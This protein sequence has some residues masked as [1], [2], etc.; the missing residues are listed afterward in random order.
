MPLLSR[1]QATVFSCNKRFRV[2]VAGRRFGKTYL[3][4][5]ELLRGA[6][7]PG[8]TVWGIAPTYRM[9][10]QISWLK[11]KEIASPLIVKANETDLTVH[12]ST[13]GIIAL[14]GA[15]N[16][17]S[18]RGVGLDGIVID[19]CADVAP[20]VWAEVVRPMLADR[21]GWALFIG[22]PKGKANHLY[23][24][25]NS[26]SQKPD[27][28]AFSYTTLQGGNVPEEEVM[29]ARAELDDKTFKQEFEASFE[30]TSEGRVYYAFSREQNVTRV[31]YDPRLPLCYSQDF[32]VS[33]MSA[34]IAQ[35]HD[36]APVP[37]LSSQ[38]TRH[39]K[40]LGE[41]V[42][43]NSNIPE[44]IGAL[45]QRIEQI[46]RPGQHIR[47]QVYG[48]ASGS[49]RSHA[50][51]SD[52]AVVQKQFQ[53]ESRFSI[54]WNLERSNPAVR[55]RVNSVNSLL[56]SA[57]GSIRLTIDPSCKELIKDLELVAWKS[58]MAGNILHDID[59]SNPER[60]HVSDSIGYLCSKEFPVGGG[61]G[62][63][64]NDTRLI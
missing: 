17:D 42:I 2:L 8:F 30:E 3:S 10:K 62:G 1:P 18:L 37:H 39:I 46:A 22:T 24:L 9:A 61:N 20:E 43:K 63:F 49:A 29:A 45:K 48:D 4:I 21:L 6:S 56:R 53:G 32:N 38:A 33:P 50:G 52:W 40:V 26:A 14:R 34:V 31:D 35:I 58:D 57:D 28:A 36:S 23:D 27:W 12:L 51:P 55:D 19:E 64:K 5:S 11:L 54:S 47:L 59:K 7:W 13:G 25:Y 60:S 15:D 44:A 41:L 16:Y